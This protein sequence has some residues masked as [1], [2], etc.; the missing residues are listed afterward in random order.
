MWRRRRRRM[1]SNMLE[2]IALIDLEDWDQGADHV[3]E[4]IAGIRLNYTQ[5]STNNAERIE[6]NPETGKLRAIAE[7]SLP[8]DHLANVLDKLRDANAIFDGEGGA[9]DMYATLLPERQIID[10]AI[11]RYS[12]RPMRLYDACSRASRRVQDKVA[13]GDCPANDAL[14]NDYVHQLDEVAVDIRGFDDV[15]K[16]VTSTR[17]LEA[18]KELPEEAFADFVQAADEVASGSEGY[19]EDEL[20]VEARKAIDPALPES[21][22][23]EALN[24]T[25]GRLVRALQ[26]GRKHLASTAG[27][28]KD[29]GIVAG[30]AGGV[31]GGVL[32]MTGKLPEVVP[33]LAWL[34]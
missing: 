31:V 23:K 16:D 3:N 7:T 34:F 25:A 15:V 9:N 32:Y 33:W 5:K 29:V 8:E 2:E 26:A 14:V 10:D 28:V 21:E 4:I 20:P 22:R 6:I 27:V 17:V 24:V 19:L 18:M 1:D 12:Q 11:Q 30:G 13:A